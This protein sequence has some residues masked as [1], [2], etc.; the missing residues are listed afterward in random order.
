MNGASVD[1]WLS[2]C[3]TESTR[4]I[5]ANSMRIFTAWYTKPP[6]DFLK[7]EPREMRHVALR[8]Q[9]DALQGWKPPWRDGAL[10]QNTIL[11]ILTALGSF[12]SYNDQFLRLRGKRAHTLI[13]LS[14]HVFTNRDLTRMFAVA[15]IEQKAILAT[16]CSLGWEVQAIL[17]LKRTYIENLIY[18]SH[19]ERQQYIYFI[20]QRG[21]TGALRLGV[22]NPLAIEWI[23]EYLKIAPRERSRSLR[24]GSPLPPNTA[25]LNNHAENL[26]FSG[27]LFSY[28]TKEGINGMLKHLA[29]DAHVTVTGRVHTHLLR[30]WV[31]SGLSRAGFNEFQIKFVVGKAIPLSDMTYLQTLQQEVEAKYPKAFEDQLDISG[32]KVVV[33]LSEEDREKLNLL[34]N[35][36]IVRALLRIAKEKE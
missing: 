17:Q 11:A 25:R 20:H 31:M 4:K 8:F 26:S 15:N 1:E 14:S 6:D 36:E 13:D 12:A 29:R 21:K 7:L 22:L 35:P 9:N 32:K 3:R 27:T 19:E 16:F 34:S 30:K 2:E 18:R 5:Y 24:E 10:K 28:T 33:G 23:E